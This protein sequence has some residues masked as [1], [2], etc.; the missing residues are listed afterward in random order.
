M[1][2]SRHLQDLVGAE[3]DPRQDVAPVLDDVRES[4]VVDDHGIESPHV[5][6]TLAGRGHGEQERLRRASVEKRSN[7]ADRFAPVVE[8]DREP[9]KS[10]P[11]DASD[12]LDR[13]ASRQKDAD[14]VP[15]ADD[16]AQE[17]GLKKIEPPQKPSR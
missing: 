7:D 1:Y 16:I 4:R 10:R 9:G 14:A 5:E 6:R 3:V 2:P 8:R 11:D 12:L 17:V 15:S 13:G